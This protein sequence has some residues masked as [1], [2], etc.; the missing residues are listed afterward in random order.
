VLRQCV[1]GDDT[2]EVSCAE[3]TGILPSAAFRSTIL[4]DDR[5]QREAYF[6][7]LRSVARGCDLVFF[8]PDNGLEVRSKPCGRS[9]SA[10]YLYYRE[11]IDTCRAGHSVLIYQHFPREK[12]DPFVRARAQTIGMHVGAEEVISFRTAHT[13]FFL[14]PQPDRLDY[15]LERSGQVQEQWG[16]QIRLERHLCH[17][18]ETAS[19]LAADL[20][21]RIRSLPAHLQEPAIAYLEQQL[22]IFEQ[23]VPTARRDD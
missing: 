18:T 13:A 7:Q 1:A 15:F 12:R 6:E 4:S 10:R 23:H 14:A 11:L 9:G 22:G 17:S 8:D 2:R 19:G 16:R 5:A 20:V 3:T 21:R